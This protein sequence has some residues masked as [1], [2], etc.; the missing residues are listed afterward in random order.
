MLDRE[1]VSLDGKVAF[2]TGGGGGIGRGI[3]EA[4]AAYGAR[5]VVAECDAG[6]ARETAEAIEKAGGRALA[7]VTDVRERD[8]VEEATRSALE[9]FDRIDILVNNVGDFLGMTQP[10]VRSTEEEWEAL[11]R[12]NLRHVFTCTHAVVPHMLERGEGGSIINVSTIEAFRGVPGCAV[13]SAFNTAITGFTR[14]LALELGPKRIRVNAIAPETTETLQVRPSEWVPP[15]NRRFV[16]YWTP[17]G[18]FGTP[19]D[20]AG[21]A[22]FLASELSAWV[23]G[24]TVHLDGGALAA[25]GFYRVPGAGWTNM[26]VLGGPG[27]LGSGK[28]TDS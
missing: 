8:Q 24:T 23:T 21:C 6:R 22:V 20:A 25:G 16:P 13:Y 12:I 9:A 18:R 7:C 11:Y 5:V 17:L 28:P 3:S 19:D 15:E 26:P 4:F 27:G 1:A 14:S 10:F 2:V